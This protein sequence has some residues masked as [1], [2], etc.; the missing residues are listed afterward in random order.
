MPYV[1]W[2]ARARLGKEWTLPRTPGELNYCLTKLID[3]YI[4]DHGLS[5]ASI[6]DVL[7]AIT[8]AQLEFYRRVAGPYEDQKRAS[9]GDVYDI[10]RKG[11]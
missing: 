6:N 7:G 4:V 10:L 3:A 9:N 1:D 11:G 5:Y 2:E 8:G